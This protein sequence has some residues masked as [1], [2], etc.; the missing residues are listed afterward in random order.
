MTIDVYLQI[1]GIKGESKDSSHPGWIEISSAH[2]GVIQPR[3]T[4][5]SSAGG[6]TTERCEHLALAL[7]TVPQISKVVYPEDHRQMAS[8]FPDKHR[9][10]VQR[11]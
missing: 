10:V 11:R 6:H 3:S 7:S 4:T 8:S 1:D 9:T 2:W 5:V